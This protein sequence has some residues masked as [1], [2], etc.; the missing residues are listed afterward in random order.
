MVISSKDIQKCLMVA[1]SAKDDGASWGNQKLIVDQFREMECMY[2]MHI[3]GSY[4]FGGYDM[5]MHAIPISDDTD[6]EFLVDSPN[7]CYGEFT[8]I[9]CHNYWAAFTNDGGQFI[10]L[11]T[12]QIPHIGWSHLFDGNYVES[13]K[14]FRKGMS[15]PYLNLVL[16]ISNARVCAHDSFICYTPKYILVS[17]YGLFVFL[18]DQDIKLHR[19]K[20]EDKI[21]KNLWRECYDGQIM[22]GNFALSPERAFVIINDMKSE[23]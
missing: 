7:K 16:D 14:A 12:S 15:A 13:T 23:N 11:H 22:G 19:L 8:M 18:P 21:V 4:K 3:P 6:R 10:W 5:K 20:T 1:Q 9:F 17:I 2:G